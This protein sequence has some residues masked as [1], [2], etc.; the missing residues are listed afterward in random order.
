MART[1]SFRD[2]PK[3]QTSD[4]QLRIGESRDSGIDAIGPRFARTRWH[5]PGMTAEMRRTFSPRNSIRLRKAEHLLGDEAQNQ[6]RADRLDAGDQG[7][8]QVRLDG[9]LLGLAKDGM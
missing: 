2:G 5:R 3:D 7:L 6:L 8:G 4:A 9:K 1:P